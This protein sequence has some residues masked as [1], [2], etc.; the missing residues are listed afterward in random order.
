MTVEDERRDLKGT[1]LK[2][3][4]INVVSGVQNVRTEDDIGLNK[5]LRHVST[6]ET[7]SRTG[8]KCIEELLNRIEQARK[9]TK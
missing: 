4:H 1:V 5:T 7:F 2:T 8:E 9:V 3:A 6:G